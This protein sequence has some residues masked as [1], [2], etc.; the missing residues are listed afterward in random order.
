MHGHSGDNMTVLSGYIPIADMIVTTFGSKCEVVIHNLED[1]QSSLVY[2][3][4]SVTGRQLGAPTTEIILQELRLHGNDV[5]DMLGRTSQTRDG[6]FIRT[7]TSFIRSPD[8]KVIGFIGINFDITAFSMVNQII[9]EFSIVHEVDQ[10]HPT[11]VES[12][13]K[14]MEEVFENL[15]ENTLLDI[16]V[17]IYDMTKRDKMRS[18]KR[19]DDKGAFLIQGSVERIANVL[20][21]SKQTIY[22]YLDET[23]TDA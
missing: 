10:I 13:A 11:T 14:N 3:K 17:P 18:V 16:Q 5:Q 15:I 7:S 1:L 19:L 4:G 22:N 12:Y 8:G 9:S 2:M 23:R 20:G 21:V 6:K